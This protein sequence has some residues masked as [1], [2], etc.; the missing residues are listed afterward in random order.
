MLYKR[1]EQKTKC[2]LVEKCP[3]C[4]GHKQA[5]LLITVGLLQYVLT[6]CVI[7]ILR[8]QNCYCFNDKEHI[9]SMLLSLT[10]IQGSRPDFVNVVYT[11]KQIIY[12]VNCAVSL[13]LWLDKPLKLS[14]KIPIS[15]HP[16]DCTVES[17]NIDA[18]SPLL[19]IAKELMLV[20]TSISA[21]L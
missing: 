10:T 8:S 18:S 11:T 3:N 17:K 1:N 7:N 20:G 6:N 15:Y 2:D 16:S 4:G 13:E 14:A 9:K 5:R 19:S 12:R 21:V